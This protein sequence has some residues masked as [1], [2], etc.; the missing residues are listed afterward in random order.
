M[1]SSKARKRWIHRVQHRMRTV[2]I[3][4]I[5]MINDWIDSDNIYRH[6]E[7]TSEYELFNISMDA[8]RIG[9]ILCEDLLCWKPVAGV[10]LYHAR[11][12]LRRTLGF[13]HVRYLRDGRTHIRHRDDDQMNRF[14]LCVESYLDLCASYDGSSPGRVSKYGMLDWDYP[15]TTW[16]PLARFVMGI[17]SHTEA[18]LLT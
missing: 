5:F 18:R 8:G 15:D 2:L 11:R 3:R 10:V 14:E 1:F 9:P 4:Y 12:M 17:C 13:K 7:V 16:L 6:F